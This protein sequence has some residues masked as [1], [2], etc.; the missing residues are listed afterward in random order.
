V[1]R[2]ANALEKF[3]SLLPLQLLKVSILFDEFLLI[4]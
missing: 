1:G 2:V 3:D 4:N